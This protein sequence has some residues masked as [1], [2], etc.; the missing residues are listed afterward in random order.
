MSFIALGKQQQQQQDY[1]SNSTHSGSSLFRNESTSSDSNSSTSAIAVSDAA[2]K[3][4]RVMRIFCKKLNTR[5]SKGELY[6]QNESEY[7]SYIEKA[8]DLITTLVSN[9]SLLAVERAENELEKER[10]AILAENKNLIKQMQEEIREENAKKKR[11]MLSE[12]TWGIALDGELTADQKKMHIFDLK[13]ARLYQEKDRKDDQAKRKKIISDR[14]RERMTGYDR[15]LVQR[16]AET[17]LIDSMQCFHD[18]NNGSPYI[19]NNSNSV[20]GKALFNL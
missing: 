12:P 11:K 15:T 20:N 13:R 5:N 16:R 8:E 1:M 17:E 18:S 3:R 9:T 6:F 10:R 2:K 4:N 19:D 14:D 7:G